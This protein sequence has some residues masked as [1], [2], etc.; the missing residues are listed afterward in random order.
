[1]LRVD[2]RLTIVTA[3]D[4]NE[5]YRLK[6]LLLILLHCQCHRPILNF[7]SI[8]FAQFADYYGTE[9]SP[10]FYSSLSPRARLHG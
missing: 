5:L 10:T 4:I 9:I 7:N 6:N 1:M 3:L 8:P 2:N